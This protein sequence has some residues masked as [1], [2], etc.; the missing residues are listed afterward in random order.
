L[1]LF[2]FSFGGFL[3]WFESHT[4]FPEL[5]DVVMQIMMKKVRINPMEIT[6]FVLITALFAG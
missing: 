4:A 3:R 1:L 5:Q 2:F 6:R